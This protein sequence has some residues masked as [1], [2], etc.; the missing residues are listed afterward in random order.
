MD[1]TR[2][3]QAPKE[4]ARPAA[5]GRVR[6]SL[7]RRL[8][9]RLTT[10]SKKRFKKVRFKIFLLKSTRMLWRSRAIPQPEPAW[11][12]NPLKVCDRC[13]LKS[14]PLAILITLGVTASTPAQERTTEPAKGEALTLKA[15]IV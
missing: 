4:A 14:F 8:R 6:R 13:R 3:N 12:T 11:L 5:A 1:L 7:S 2:K 15:Q 10:F 9:A